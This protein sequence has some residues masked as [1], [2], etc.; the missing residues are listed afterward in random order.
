MASILGR[1]T[2]MQV[3]YASDGEQVCKGCAYLAPPDKHLEIYPPGVI[4]LSD[5]PK[6]NFARPAVDRLFETAASTYGSRVIGLVL[7]GGDS[8]GADGSRAITHAGGITLAQD[9]R[10]ASVPSMPLEAIRVDHPV[11]LL[12]TEVIGQVLRRMVCG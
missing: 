1:Y 3:V 12:K 5:G 8:D 7:S 11:A 4:Y 6:V 9:P 10:D 2:S